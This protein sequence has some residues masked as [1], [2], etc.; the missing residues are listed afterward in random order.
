[1]PEA[2]PRPKPRFTGRAAILVV[3]FAVLVVSY[4]SSMR[5]YLRQQ[6]HLND[7]R[8]E[9]AVSQKRIDNLQRE[10]RRWKDEAYVETQARQ[11]FGWVLPGEVS[12][13]VIG[14]DGKPLSRGDELS[15]PGEVVKRV[16]TAWWSEA[17][18]TLEEADHPKKKPT[19][20]SRIKPPETEQQDS[21]Q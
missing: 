19:P 6:A 21:A 20:A 3:V 5:A 4:A 14:R 2:A 11:R 15:N 7:L 16:P 12:Y 1:M 10:K 18:G 17:Y 13:Q 9:I 8:D